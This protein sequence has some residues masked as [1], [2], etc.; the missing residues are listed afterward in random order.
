M[1]G[2]SINCDDYRHNDFLIH[3]PHI[4]NL[5]SQGMILYLFMLLDFYEVLIMRDGYINNHCAA[6]IYASPGLLAIIKSV[7]MKNIW[8]FSIF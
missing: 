1:R 2:V 6:L 4:D 5:F 3:I 7:I 8:D